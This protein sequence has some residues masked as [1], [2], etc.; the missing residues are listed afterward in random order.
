MLILLCLSQSE[1]WESYTS[2][3]LWILWIIIV[4]N[5]HKS[6]HKIWSFGTSTG[7]CVFHVCRVFSRFSAVR[8]VETPLKAATT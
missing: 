6:L 5:C 1:P 3:L 2:L 4:D 7:I 8:Q